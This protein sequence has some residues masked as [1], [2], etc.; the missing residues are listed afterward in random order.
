MIAAKIIEGFVFTLTVGAGLFALYLLVDLLR[1]RGTVA[2]KAYKGG[3]GQWSWVAHRVTGLGVIAFLFGHI[4]DTFMVGFG[5]ELYNETISLYQQWWFKPFEVL[6]IGATLYHALN[7]M[8][9]I[10]F[11]FWPGLAVRQRSF[12]YVELTLFMAGFAPAA[13]FM[14]R[15]AYE[16]S[17]FG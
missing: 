13:F 17:P 12:A 3:L 10:M 7:G 5:P 9:I 4:V 1:L 14:L 2:G 6:L 15:S 8:R 16:T 11:D